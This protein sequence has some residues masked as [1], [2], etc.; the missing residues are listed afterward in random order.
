M[1]YAPT[2]GGDLVNPADDL[3]VVECTR[4]IDLARSAVLVMPPL[5][6]VGRDEAMSLW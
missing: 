4:P 2:H 6:P 5:R 1:Q 3:E